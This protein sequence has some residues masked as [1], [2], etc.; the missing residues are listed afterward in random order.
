[1]ATTVNTLLN[2]KKAEE[3]QRRRESGEEVAPSA[4]SV[5]KA[6]RDEKKAAKEKAHEEA[7]SDASSPL[8][9]AFARGIDVV[10][11][12]SLQTVL[13][14]VFVI[15]FQV[16]IGSVRM[17]EEYYFDKHL[18]DRIVENTFDSSHNTLETVRRPADIYEWGNNV[19]IPGLFADMG[20][21]NERVG[22]RGGVEAKGCNDDAWFDGAGSFFLE[23]ATPFSVAELV[24]RMDQFDWTDGVYIRQLRARPTRCDGIRQRGACLPELTR[25]E[26]STE[27]FGY[28][29]TEPGAPATHS[30]SHFTADQLGASPDGIKSAQ[31]TSMREYDADGFV[32][33]AIPFF[34]DALLPAQERLPSPH[35]P[36]S[37]R[38]SPSSPTPSCLRRRGCPPRSSTTGCTTP[39]RQTGAPR[40]TTA[41]ASLRTVGTSSSCATG[42]PTATARRHSE[43]TCARPWRSGG[44]T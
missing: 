13:Y 23:G 28:N 30:W 35:L 9:R 25:G 6:A 24:E 32:A 3:E 12:T 33:L 19:L 21:C 5:A 7:K 26:G 18:M 15:V 34:S 44:T 20:P 38:I 8:R 4:A 22:E 11:S 40:R 37:P 1:M 10:N 31:I 41:S 43:A 42:A 14:L 27:T 39:R 2:I 29:W 36:T 16:L 17:T